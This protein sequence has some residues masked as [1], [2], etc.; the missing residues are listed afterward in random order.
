VTVKTSTAR[1]DGTGLRVTATARTWSAHE[2]HADP[3]A[4]VRP[5]SVESAQS[6][7]RAG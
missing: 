2:I 4:P 1:Y 7:G 3:V 5:A 6:I